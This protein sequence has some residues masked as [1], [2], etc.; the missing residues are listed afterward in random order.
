MTQQKTVASPDL[1]SL[2]DLFK[3]EILLGLNCHAIGVVQLF[4][5]ATQTAQV[6]VA[7]KKT[8]Y[9]GPDINVPV[10]VDYPVLIDCPVV[11]LQGG[12]AT[13]TF[14]IKPNDTCLVLFNDRDID[15]WF[16]SGQSGPVATQRLH[17]FSDG[18]A[19]IGVN[20]LL[21]VL[22]D[23]DTIRAVM[24][25][26]TT[27]VGVGPVLVKIS[28]PSGSLLTVING[29]IDQISSLE[30]ALATFAAALGVAV[31]PAA[32]AAGALASTIATLQPALIAY[33]TA[34]VGALL[35]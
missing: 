35:E 23:Y 19:L 10:Y 1:K 32:P 25:N 33:K 5:S 26:G 4:D 34:V 29:L 12:G 21:T 2:L 7:Y 14:P 20:S 28:N 16:K 11:V 24:K 27:M 6:Q 9:N 8:Y 15:N 13:L 3:K 18:F 31:P 17:A 22:Q 30:L